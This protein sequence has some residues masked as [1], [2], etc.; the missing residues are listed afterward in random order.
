MLETPQALFN[1]TDYDPEPIQGDS[2]GFPAEIHVA[3]VLTF[4]TDDGSARK[5]PVNLLLEDSRRLVFP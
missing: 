3:A 1:G 2:L 4:Y 5:Q